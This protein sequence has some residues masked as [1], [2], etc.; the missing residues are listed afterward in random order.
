[1]EDSIGIE[2]IAADWLARRDRGA[3]SDTD[4]AELTAWMD[5]STAHRI[6]YIRLEAV[7]ESAR[8][9]KTLALESPL[10]DAPRPRV[11]P[12][13]PVCRTVKLLVVSDDSTS[14][15]LEAEPPE[16]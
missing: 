7:W 11:L 9:L 8:C 5:A 6:A 16:Q 3:W 1:M 13:L 4:Q 15:S 14:P 12:Y 10:G 2:E